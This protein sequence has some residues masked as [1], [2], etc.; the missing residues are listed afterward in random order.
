MLFFLTA[1]EVS[2]DM[3]FMNEFIRYQRG[4]NFSKKRHITFRKL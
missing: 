2:L 4:S 1:S 3:H